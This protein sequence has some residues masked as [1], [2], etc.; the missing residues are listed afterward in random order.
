MKESFKRI[1]TKELVM[2]MVKRQLGYPFDPETE[3]G[4]RQS[5]VREIYKTT[6]IV[7]TFVLL[8]LVSLIISGIKPRAAARI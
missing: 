4:F 7:V 8:V 3:H 2:S 6:L 1:A 5:A